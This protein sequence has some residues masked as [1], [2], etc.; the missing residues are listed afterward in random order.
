MKRYLHPLKGFKG[1]ELKRVRRVDETIVLI[2]NEAMDKVPEVHN[3]LIVKPSGELGNT[4]C[5]CARY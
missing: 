5:V 1:T 4:L 3:K 2:I